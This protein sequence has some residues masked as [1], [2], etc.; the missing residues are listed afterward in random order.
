M[1]FYQK[2]LVK[3]FFMNNETHLICSSGELN[4]CADFSYRMSVQVS[5]EIYLIFF[6]FGM[7]NLKISN[8]LIVV[9]QKIH[10]FSILYYLEMV[11]KQ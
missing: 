2:F 1:E 9:Y 8:D 5:S 4:L 6:R 3:R 11:K 10:F 7:K